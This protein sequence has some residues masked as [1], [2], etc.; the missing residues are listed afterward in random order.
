MR[1]SE[2]DI[3]GLGLGLSVLRQFAIDKTIGAVC[4]LV[5]FQRIGEVVVRVTGANCIRLV[6]GTALRAVK[7]EVMIR[8]Q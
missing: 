3:L 8:G 4:F 6:L 1:L 5:H 2:P 7:F